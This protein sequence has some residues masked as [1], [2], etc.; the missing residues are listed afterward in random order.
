MKDRQDLRSGKVEAVTRTPGYDE[1]TIFSPDERLGL[2]MTARF[3]EGT[4]LKILDL[5]PRP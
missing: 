4:D 2:T 5:I 1:T 3:S